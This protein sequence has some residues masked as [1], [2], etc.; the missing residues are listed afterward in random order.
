M[1]RLQT[2]GT[3][4]IIMKDGDKKQA[5]IS[6]LGKIAAHVPDLI[7]YG[8]FTQE[9]PCIESFDG[10]LLFVDIS[11]FTALTEKFSMNTNLDCGADQLTQT[12]NHYVGDIVE[13]VLIFGGDVLKFAGDAILALWRVERCHIHD[14]IT[15]A[16]KC[17]FSI[18][19][20]FS[21]YDVEVGL[22]L[23][24]KIGL[25]AGHI[26]KVLIGDNRHQYFL[27]IGRAVD[28]VRLA[29]NLAK[30]S[31]IILSPNCWE[32]CD[33]NLIEVE[34]IQGERAVRVR[35]IKNDFDNEE[36]F[37]RCT[38]HLYQHHTCENF[39]ILRYASVLAP[40]EELEKSL[41]K[42]VMRN[43][44]RKID[45]NQPLE[46]LSELRP[47]TIVF[48]NLQFDETANALHLCKAI[49]DANAKITGIIDPLSGKINKLFM[50]DKGCTLLCIFGLPGD[51]QPNE[52]THALDSAHKIHLFC[53]TSLMKLKIVSV[54]VTSG[55]V[56]C[57]V[58]GHRVRHEY[59]VI[60]RKV[61]LAARMMMYYPG[62]VSCDAVTYT[63]C[64]LPHYFFEELP[65]IEMKGVMNPGT[66]Y[67]YLGFSEKTMIYKAYL[68]QEQNDHYPL[69]GRKKE[70]DIFE[71]SLKT[72]KQSRKSQVIMY[73]GPMG[74]GKS[75]LMAEIA[76][77]GQAPG[78]K[79]VAI[80]LTKI[81]IWQNFFAVRTLMAMFL[82]IDTC[83]TY[84]AR[85]YVLVNKLRGIVEDEY[86]CLLNN[87]FH[88]KFPTSEVVSRMDN[89]ERNT[90]MEIMLRHILKQIRDKE[91]VIFVIDESQYIDT[92][93]W[94][95][96]E[97]M[98]RT[99][100]IFVVMSLCPD[101]R[102]ARLPCP[103]AARIRNHHNTV[104]IH[105]RELPPSVI[106]QKACQ[107]LGVVSI[108]RELEIFL[109]QRSHGNPFYC[110]ELLRNLHFNN[111]LQFHVL[112]ED[113]E[114]EDEWDNIFT[115]GV[116]KAQ[117]SKSP[118]NKEE[119]LYICTIR[120][121]VK[122]HN[123]MLPPTLK[124]IA[125]AELDN[126]TPSEQ[127]VVKCAAVIGV[128]F[129]TE[130]LLHILPEWTKMKM[131]Q[132][133]ATLVDSRIFQCFG[134]RKEVH[135]VKS[136]QSVSSEEL[137]ISSQTVKSIGQGS[138]LGPLVAERL[139]QEEMVMHCKVMG[140]CTPL[141]QEAA[142]ELWLKSQKEA[143]HLKCAS[144][145]QWHAHQCKC[146]GQGDFISFHRYAVEGMLHNIDTQ[147]SRMQFL[148]ES[149]LNEAATVLVSEMLMKVELS[150][151]NGSKDTMP[152]VHTTEF[153]KET[154]R[155][156]SKVRRSLSFLFGN[157]RHSP[158]F[159]LRS[160]ADPIVS[161]L[162]TESTMARNNEETIPSLPIQ[163]PLVMQDS[164]RAE[165]TEIEFLNRMDEIILL[166]EMDKK[167][168]KTISSCECEEILESVIVPLSHHCLAVEDN[169]WAFYYL[170]ECAAAYVY[171]ANNYMAFTYL[172]TA[173]TLLKSLD[174]KE[175]GI[176][177]F[178]ESL[179]YSLKGEV[180]YNMGQINL[181]K[182]L[183]KKALNL[184]KKGFPLTIIGAFFMSM[185]ETSKHMSHQKKQFSWQTHTG[186][187]KRLATLYQQGHCLSLLWQIFSLDLAISSKKFARL[188]ALMKV[189]CAEETQDESQII[190]SYMEFSLCCQLMG[191]QHE[192]MKYELMAIKRSSQ[193]R[194]VGGGLLTIA[195][196]ALSLAYMKLCLGNM[197]LAIQLG[198]RA[199]KLCVL[200]KK[201]KLD[202]IVLSDLFRALFLNTR[203]SEAVE[204]LSW[205]EELSFRDDNV[206]GK[207]C[208]ISG[209]LD[210]MLYAGFSFK[211][212][213]HCLDFILTN[214]T[215]CILMSQNSIMLDLY[216]S[217]AIWFA[218]LQL[219]D[220]FKE[221]FEKAR[222]LLRRTS[223]SFSA[224]H[225]FCKFVESEAL[226]LRKYIEDSP[227]KARETLGKMARDLEQAISQCSTSPVY[228]PRVYHLKAY[229]QLM[230][231]YDDYSQMF[232][233][234][235]IQSSEI[236]GNHL[237]LSWLEI[238]K[239]WWFTGTAPMEDC[240]LNTAPDFPV[241]KTGLALDKTTY[242]KTKYLLKVPEF[243]SDSLFSELESEESKT[244]QF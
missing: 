189:N 114:K 132:T 209:C 140:F 217:L 138:D 7:V 30:A 11:G 76:F 84:D 241:W 13:D 181:A 210:L 180:S 54:G 238:T 178:E 169:A 104:Y 23:K 120:Q 107:D 195:K 144:Y 117:A 93:S 192:W 106:V 39:E 218:R 4:S 243:E 128:T 64:K 103:A 193:L 118:E 29:Q 100:P 174:A 234:K 197:A 66:V 116:L 151:R 129:E 65:F 75:Q 119:D 125:L 5:E 53:S 112:E 41:R 227:E 3:V 124:G 34:K 232:L 130:L 204:V 6:P 183:I 145:L 115:R 166:T 25:S 202:Y 137:C 105:L 63:T 236:Y 99:V 33:R 131:N 185:V 160:S 161:S 225:G 171:L 67:K 164:F 142:Y 72:F 244:E 56:F 111:V 203:F 143:L 170:L 82:G 223:T 94:Q 168:I 147:E 98:I 126:M 167:K 18:Q 35:Y 219:W 153:S 179:L 216:S 77:L 15:L 20:V 194:I 156:P 177:Q 50:F 190:S 51:K 141:L 81:N 235:A 121:N 42:Y 57:G 40:D 38:A 135:A 45:D 165:D 47:V 214:E 26:S 123:I 97:K 71:N 207:A 102:K 162:S 208:F 70:T 62:L 127:M 21:D 60:G 239:E 96:L 222:R 108:A 122:L 58:V 198:Y 172:N 196:L 90:Q 226:L 187:E 158:D 85:Q 237:E 24:V 213:K 155:M 80:E 91:V 32:L 224:N 159:L 206:I 146:C 68:T 212:F 175:K 149:T 28:E 17:S 79:V 205:L 73:D 2:P 43:V 228:Y 87:L 231:G 211:P 74:Y 83:K 233:E 110:E 150:R 188:A 176:S 230:L 88:V 184:L 220:D 36:F 113:E 134:E 49:Q 59:T 154:F 201:P 215:N 89:D 78:Q 163:R 31:E 52:S 22:E 86:L 16:V 109:I 69:L 19:Q 200:L 139:K 221:P 199:H 182:K 44:L 173:E 14:I 48:V 8:D 12:L 1:N 229:V 186:R 157:K 148:T 136:T 37:E 152:A 242:S 55:P 9:V 95:F 61:N 46:Y 101:N 10:V 240:W 133:L 27:V 92:V 191:C